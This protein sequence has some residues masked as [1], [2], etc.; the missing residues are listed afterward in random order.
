MSFFPEY[1]WTQ[2]SYHFIPCQ[3]FSRKWRPEHQSWPRWPAYLRY[4]KQSNLPLGWTSADPCSWLCWLEVESLTCSKTNYEPDLW[5][6]HL[7]ISGIIIDYRILQVF[8]W[9]TI[10][11]FPLLLCQESFPMLKA[12]G[13]SYVVPNHWHPLAPIRPHTRHVKKSW[14]F[15]QWP[16][17]AEIPHIFLPGRPSCRRICSSPWMQQHICRTE[18]HNMINIRKSNRIHHWSQ[19]GKTDPNSEKQNSS[20]AVT[21]YTAISE[22]KFRTARDG[23]LDTLDR[24]VLDA[25]CWQRL[26]GTNKQT[27]KQQMTC[28]GSKLLYNSI[29]IIKTY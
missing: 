14:S 25:T 7:R 4:V 29:Y 6:G 27:N 3:D 28:E 8:C 19:T 10:A 11:P 26:K 20:I 5:K 23:R 12:N 22:Y 21:N 1:I 13:S 9:H 18:T 17:L 24:D 15:D 16:R 2:T